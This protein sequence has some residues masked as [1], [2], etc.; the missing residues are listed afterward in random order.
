MLAHIRHLPDEVKLKIRYYF[1]NLRMSFE[2]F[3]LKN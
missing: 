1:K 3:K 2:E